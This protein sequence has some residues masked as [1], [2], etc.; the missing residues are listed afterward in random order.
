MMEGSGSGRS[1]TYGSGT[2]TLSKRLGFSTCLDTIMVVG[3]FLVIMII[4]GL[5]MDEMACS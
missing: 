2:T 3:R 5:A 1:K 4:R